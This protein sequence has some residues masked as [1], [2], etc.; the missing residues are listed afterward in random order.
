MAKNLTLRIDE[1]VL[2][3]ARHAAVEEDLSLSQWVTG[4]IRRAV[5]QD[6]EYERARREAMRLMSRG[7]HLGGKPLSRDELHER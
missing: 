4:V 1:G 6:T 2:R 7:F 5:G 3:K